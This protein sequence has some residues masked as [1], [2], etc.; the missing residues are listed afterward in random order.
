MKMK[1]II[2]ENLKYIFTARPGE[3]ALCGRVSF[4][5]EEVV[6]PDY[7]YYDN[8]KYRVVG[9]TEGAFSN[10]YINKI[11]LPDTL[12]YISDYAFMSCEYLQEI[13]LPNNITYIGEGAFFGCQYLKK[14][15]L[16]D[17]LKRLQKRCFAHCYELQ[18]IEL[19]NGLEVI[20]EGVFDSCF[21]LKE[22]YIPETVEFMFFP[23]CVETVY[24]PYGKKHIFEE[25]LK[26]E[27]LDEKIKIISIT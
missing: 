8:K 3:V 27:G 16:S 5:E 4:T 22:L 10:S 21:K 23:E 6:I 12:E 20:E 2:V 9:I 26:T 17:N 24:V 14:V 18:G 13:Y 15:H 19:P 11:T 1:E 25:S 7:I